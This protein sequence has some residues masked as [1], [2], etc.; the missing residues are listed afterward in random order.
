MATLARWARRFGLT[1]AICILPL[2][3]RRRPRSLRR[4]IRSRR[5]SGAKEKDRVDNCQRQAIEQ[6]SCRA[7]VRNSSSTVW[8]NR[9]GAAS[10]SYQRQ[11]L[12]GRHDQA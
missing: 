3:G 6:K 11:S 8:K 5:Q 1:R 9:Y 4:N 2:P 12:R 7:I 10:E